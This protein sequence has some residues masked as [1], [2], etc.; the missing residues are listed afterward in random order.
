MD[1]CVGFSQNG[2]PWANTCEHSSWRIP[3]DITAPFYLLFVPGQTKRVLSQIAM[4]Q[5]RNKKQKNV[6]LSNVPL[7]RARYKCKKANAEIFTSHGENFKDSCFGKRVCLCLYLVTL[8][9]C[10]PTTSSGEGGEGNV[11]IG[12]HFPAPGGK[13]I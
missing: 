4:E 2:Y 6:S 12:R 9:C 11:E 3:V 1:V 5:P 7:C 8:D 10:H 13:Q